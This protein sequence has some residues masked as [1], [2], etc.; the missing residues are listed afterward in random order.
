M[1]SCV[2]SEVP[3]AIFVRAQ[4]ASNCSNSQI[5]GATRTGIQGGAHGDRKSSW[6]RARSATH[7]KL[8]IVLSKKSDEKWNKTGTN[9]RLYRRVFFARKQFAG[10]GGRVDL[11]RHIPGQNLLY[12]L[13]TLEKD[14]LAFLF[15]HMLLHGKCLWH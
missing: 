4:A 13:R 9:N 8:G 3:D 6:T 5:M 12:Q 14:P 7:L 2:C 11:L 15:P 1:I 10:A